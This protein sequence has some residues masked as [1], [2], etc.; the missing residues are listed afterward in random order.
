QSRVAILAEQKHVG[1]DGVVGPIARA[2]HEFGTTLIGVIGHHA[3]GIL[4]G[5]AESLPGVLLFQR[6][7]LLLHRPAM[8][9]GSIYDH[10]HSNQSQGRCSKKSRNEIAPGDASSHCG[11]H[12]DMFSIWRI[13]AESTLSRVIKTG[14]TLTR[15]DSDAP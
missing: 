14:S 8:R 11:D 15:G 9:D 4:P 2:S 10:S 5:A 7:D 13:S 3:I 6:D 1:F 12:Q